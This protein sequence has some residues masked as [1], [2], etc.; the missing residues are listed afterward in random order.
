MVSHNE[1]A[2]RTTIVS[3]YKA[4]KQTTEPTCPVRTGLI[5]G[6]EHAAY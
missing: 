2:K 1:T 4:A 6:L 3:L 5:V